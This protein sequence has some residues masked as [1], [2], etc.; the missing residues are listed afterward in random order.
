MIARHLPVLQIVVPLIA[1]PLCVLLRGARTTWA[2]ALGVSWTTFGISVALLTRVLQDGVLRYELGG[3]A[4]PWGI[5][6]RVDA[7]SAFVLLFVSF[8]GALVLTY[9]PRSVAQEIPESRHYL[10]YATYLL[11]LTGLLGLSSADV[12]KLREEGV[13]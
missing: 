2:F 8:I 9:A 13:V 7:L 6:Y 1:A 5:E 12:A 4:V 3:W 11:C 10:F